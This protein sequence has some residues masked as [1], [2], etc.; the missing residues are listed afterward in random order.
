MQLAE[1]NYNQTKHDDAVA[2]LRAQRLPIHEA[3]PA[4]VE[5]YIREYQS[6]AYKINC[7]LCEDFAHDLVFVLGEDPYK[8]TCP[9]EIRWHDEMPDCS[10][11]EADWWAHC[12]VV[13][14]GR[15]YDSEASTG[16]DTWRDLPSFKNNPVRHSR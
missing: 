5:Y 11:Y 14:Q 13:Y 8:H 16:V 12:F 1:L 6:N 9:I 7:G 10:E 4:L 2:L 15:F 3:I